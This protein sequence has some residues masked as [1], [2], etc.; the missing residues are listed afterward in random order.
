MTTYDRAFYPAAPILDIY[1]V[2]PKDHSLLLAHFVL[3]LDGKKQT[4]ELTDP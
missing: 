3:T 1:V 2:N 4:F